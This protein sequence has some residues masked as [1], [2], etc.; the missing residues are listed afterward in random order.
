[1]Y[2]IRFYKKIFCNAKSEGTS[3][4][5]GKKIILALSKYCY[6]YNQILLK[7]FCALLNLKYVYIYVV[8]D[9]VAFE[10]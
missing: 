2:I 1:M 9:G 6:V 10:H 4:Q 8:I 5:H 3:D 7:T